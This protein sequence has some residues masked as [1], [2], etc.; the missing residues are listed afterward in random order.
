MEL[1]E[2]AVW[3]VSHFKRFAWLYDPETILVVPKNLHSVLLQETYVCNVLVAAVSRSSF[4]LRNPEKQCRFFFVK[5][6]STAEQHLPFSYMESSAGLMSISLHFGLR[7]RSRSTLLNYI[8]SDALWNSL[9]TNLGYFGALKPGMFL[10]LIRLYASI[11]NCVVCKKGSLLNMLC[12][13]L[14][15]CCYPTHRRLAY[16]LLLLTQ[17]VLVLRFYLCLIFL[18]ASFDKCYRN[19]TLSSLTWRESVMTLC[20]CLWYET[21]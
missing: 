4:S 21:N 15:C 17:R 19:F 13:D 18:T 8:A 10:L 12:S 20:E 16:K 11:S 6:I 5:F 3:C 9:L 14:I 7:F 2:D 1:W